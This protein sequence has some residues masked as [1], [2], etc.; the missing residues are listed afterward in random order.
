MPSQRELDSKLEALETSLEHRMIAAIQAAMA[1]CLDPI[2]TLTERMADIQQRLC[3]LDENLATAIGANLELRQYQRLLEEKDQRL[4]EQSS[5]LDQARYH[6]IETKRQLD[7]AN[8]RIEILHAAIDTQPNEVA[9]DVGDGES[10]DIETQLKLQLDEALSELEHLREQNSDLATRI[11]QRTTESAVA[12]NANGS[13]NQGTMSWEERKKLMLEQLEYHAE[14]CDVATQANLSNRHRLEMEELIAKTDT[15]IERRDHEIQELREIVHAQAEARDGVA[16]GA[17]G[18][19]QILDSN[20]LILEE[21]ERL[22]AIQQEWESKLRQ[23]E[24][25]LS[26]ERAKLAR[27][28]AE[29]ESQLLN[30][31]QTE[32][33]EQAARPGSRGD[34][35]RRWLD[36]L[37][38]KEESNE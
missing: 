19:A 27:E 6:L 11:A 38:L 26:M 22:Q 25:D 3:D 33:Q 14:T 9:R 15:E 32:A 31:R 28:R 12:S 29:L 37:G 2:S 34:R 8:E 7:E 21:R 5:T 1:E 16:V 23:A 30:V 4:A 10:S 36:Y 24:I 17:A 18:V 35:Q 20:E 13:M